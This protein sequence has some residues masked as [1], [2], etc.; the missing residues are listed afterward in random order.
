MR[1]S[2]PFFLLVLLLVGMAWLTACAGDTDTATTSAPEATD[3]HAGKTLYENF[4]L[5]CH[6][7]SGKG[8][9]PA[10]ATLHP[11]PADLMAL[12]QTH[13]DASL[14]TR[15]AEGKAGTAMPAWRDVLNETQIRQILAYLR[16]EKQA[17]QSSTYSSPNETP[18]ERAV[19]TPSP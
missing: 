8:D 6:G 4:C 11:Q 5:S 10:A 14:T 12:L 9:G 13:D 18:T 16:A 15:I 17:G 19:N 2:E 1:T 3:A 7:P